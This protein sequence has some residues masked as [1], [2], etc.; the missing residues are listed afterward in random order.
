MPDTKSDNN[1]NRTIRSIKNALS[2]RQYMSL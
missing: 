1:F 2:E